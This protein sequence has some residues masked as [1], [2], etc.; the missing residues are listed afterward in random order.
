MNLSY[1]HWLT[2]ALT[3][4]AVAMATMVLML[5]NASAQCAPFDLNCMNLP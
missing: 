3:L 5:V 2:M 1:H 4:F